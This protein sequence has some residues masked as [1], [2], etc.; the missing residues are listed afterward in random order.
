MMLLYF[1]VILIQMVQITYVKKC[2]RKFIIEFFSVLCL[3]AYFG[4][5]LNITKMITIDD[6]KYKL[7]DYNIMFPKLMGNNK[8]F[9]F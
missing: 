8:M 4:Q 6:F 3:R 1:A 5:H 9:V 7:E 2:R